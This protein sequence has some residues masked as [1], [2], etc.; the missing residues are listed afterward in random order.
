MRLKNN[1]ASDAKLQPTTFRDSRID[2][3]LSATDQFHPCPKDVNC[4][5]CSATPGTGSF[6]WS[7]LDA[8]YCISLQTRPDRTDEAARQFHRVGLCRLVTFYRPLKPEGSIIKGIW[9]SH[10]KVAAH[11]L[12]AGSSVIAVFEDDVVFASWLRPKTVSAIGRALAGLPSNWM[13]F[14]LGHWPLWSFFVRLRVL[15]TSS[16]CAHAYVA[17]SRL[18][19]WLVEHVEKDPHAPRYRLVGAGIDSRF[20]AMRDAYAFFPMIAKQSRSPS[21]HPLF[22]GTAS[23]PLRRRLLVASCRFLVHSGMRPAECIAVVL[24]PFTAMAY[25]MRVLWEQHFRR[26]VN[27]NAGADPAS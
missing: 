20:A 2:D 15:R 1:K 22:S 4:E 17:G 9:T 3:I 5:F 14:F 26:G 19:N 18:L 23:T 12:A 10:R 24:S 13:L 25:G 7:F 21:D 27:S 11:A 16:G 6:D 8:A